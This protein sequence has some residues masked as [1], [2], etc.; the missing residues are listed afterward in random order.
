M[1]TRFTIYLALALSIGLTTFA[2]VPDSGQKAM[3]LLAP[4]GIQA[5]PAH[6]V[7]P[8]GAI[9]HLQLNSIERLAFDLDELVMSALP[10]EIAPPPLQNLLSEPHPLLAFMGLQTVKAPL[11]AALISSMTGIDIT[12]P[13]S[14]T[15]YVAPGGTSFVISI[16]VA[17]YRTFTG[18]MMNV[19]MAQLLEPTSLQGVSCYHVQPTKPDLPRDLYV[20]CAPERAYICTSA[21][22]ASQLGSAPPAARMSDADFVPSTIAENEGS[23]LLLCIDTG[24]LTQFLPMVEASFLSINPKQ[25]E[26]LRQ[27]IPAEMK[28]S[29]NARL[30]AQS[31]FSSIDELL[32]YTECFAVAAYEVLVQDIIELVRGAEG[33]SLILNIDKTHQALKISVASSQIQPENG[34]QPLAVADIQPFLAKLPG[35]KNI[36]SISGKKPQAKPSAFTRR[37]VPLVRQKMKAKSLSSETTENFLSH[38][39]S[40]RPKQPM[41]SLAPWTL[42]THL[43][44]EAIAAPEG[45]ETLDA[46]MKA[47]A[48]VTPVQPVR[49]SIMPIAGDAL[50]AHFV[51]ETRNAK[52]EL[53]SCE[54]LSAMAG[55]QTPLI[56]KDLKMYASPL[57]ND[58]TQLTMST[59]YR[60]RLG[61]FSFDEHELVNRRFVNYRAISDYLCIEQG[62]RDPRWLNSATFGQSTPVRGSI[63]KLLERAPAQVNALQVLTSD[64]IVTD[65]LDLAESAERTVHTELENYLLMVREAYADSGTSVNTAALA[66]SMPSYVAAVKRHAGSGEIFLALP[67]D[68]TY[69][70]AMW[71]PSVRD[72]FKDVIDQAGSTGGGAVYARTLE[73]RHE[74]ELVQNSEG[75]ALLIRSV[76]NHIF[77]RYFKTP[78]GQEELKKLTTG[79]YDG[80]TGQDVI[81]FANPAGM[82]MGG[83]PRP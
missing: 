76:G 36:I 50:K 33:M 55:D 52:L 65:L 54:A 10:E 64:S 28:P 30:R 78:E 73:G 51:S 56:N 20:L 25:I 44:G 66:Q 32:D 79:D 15:L 82:M 71:M 1:K 61:Y 80:G 19:T 62:A 26:Q 42:T 18:T 46:W 53:R 41:E 23:D 81:L 40:I 60:T 75:L 48:K 6:R 2:Q 58:I 4:T 70:R 5:G 27:M 69:P 12:K 45:A 3:T 83:I 16:P 34:T 8:R 68:L 29:I 31:N 49:A 63:L 43:Q 7:L 22:T 74:V 35:S 72:C 21:M 9:C 67:G 77:S 38:L 39:L 57:G 17:D 59:I 47:L 13:L 37:W 11:D 24:I 14:V